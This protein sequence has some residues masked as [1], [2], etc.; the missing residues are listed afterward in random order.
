MPGV[1]L[2]AL[3]QDFGNASQQV[4]R[5]ATQVVNKVGAELKG[6][7]QS[8]APVDT[9]FHRSAVHGYPS[10]PQSYTVEAGAHYAIYLEWGTWKMRPQPIL[11]NA[12]HTDMIEGRLE[13]AM[14]QLGRQ[15]MG[16]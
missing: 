1:E 5:R 4:S 12:P 2:R 16:W 3:A 7:A 8:A 13:E 11:T 14:R 15:V 10:G 9:G 6:L